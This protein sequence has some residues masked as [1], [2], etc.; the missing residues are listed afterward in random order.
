MQVHYMRKRHLEQA[1]RMNQELRMAIEFQRRLLAVNP[2]EGITGIVPS[3][4]QSNVDDHGVGGDYLDIRSGPDGCYAVLLGDVSGHGM[5]TA[6]VAAMLKAVLTPEFVAQEEWI[7]APSAFLAW[8]NTRMC[9]ITDQFPDMFVA[10][11]ACVVD[12]DAGTITYSS[13][14]N[15]LPL[16]QRGN[17]IEPV[18]VY[19]VA[20]GVNSDAE[21]YD[22]TLPLRPGD[23]LYLYTDGLHLPEEGRERAD[24]ET[25]YRAILEA[26]CRRPLAGVVD[27]LR[28]LATTDALTDDLTAVRLLA[29]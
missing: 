27:H 15:P 28:H 1:S 7:S 22:R 21:Y 20:L 10:F 25:I 2:P 24:R 17:H 5:R 6:F 12:P 9:E 11:S 29:E 26:G 4:H 13:A 8:L 14:G 18:E 23:A 3:W 16:H 19:G